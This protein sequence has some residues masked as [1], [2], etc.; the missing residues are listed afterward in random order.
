MKKTVFAAANSVFFL[1][2]FSSLA[3]SFDGPLQ[4]KNQFPLFLGVNQPYL[5][6]AS[7]QDSFSVG[8]SHSSVFVME[9]SASWTARMDMELTE[10]DMRFSRKIGDRYTVGIDVPVVRQGGGFFDHPLAEFHNFLGWGDYGRS[11]RPMNS[12]L[13]EIR[14]NGAPVVLGK[15][16]LS[17]LGDVRLSVKSVVLQEGPVVSILTNVEL[18]TG[19]PDV[20]YGNG[21]VDA[22]IAV[23]ADMRLG[24]T[25]TSFANIG[26]VFPGDLKAHQTVYLRNFA[27]AGFGI[28]AAYWS[29]FS[30]LVQTMAQTSPLP[31]TGIRQLD[32]PGVLLSFGGRY[33]SGSSSFEFSLTEDVDTAGAPDFIANI[34]FKKR[35]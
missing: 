13:Y 35:F 29:S 26:A 23:L 15:N 3:F 14:R 4:V 32:W 28:E 30:L 10:L 27:Y 34:T 5:E 20:G 18:P 12:F 17:G 33:Y 6:S 22:A 7:R 8:L 9:N 11:S 21:S 24:D 19:D 25:Y 2:L 16:D 31:R 1:F